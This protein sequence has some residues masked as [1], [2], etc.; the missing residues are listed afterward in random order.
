MYHTHVNRKV[1]DLANALESDLVITQQVKNCIGLPRLAELL[2]V[3]LLTPELEASLK[4][5]REERDALE[6]L[7]NRL[8]EQNDELHRRV[9][10]LDAQVKELLQRK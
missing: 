8:S 10:H 6:D 7:S 3:T 9:R 5:L 2:D 1:Q 4:D